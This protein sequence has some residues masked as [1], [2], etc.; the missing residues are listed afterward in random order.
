MSR[1]VARLYVAMTS[2]R[3]ILMADLGADY[4]ATMRG[5]LSG[6]YAAVADFRKD[7]GYGPAPS[8]Q[9]AGEQATFARPGS[10]VTAWSAAFQLI[11]SG[12]E[13]LTAF[14]KTVT[15]PME[16]IA[17]WTCVRSMLESCAIAAWLL[18]PDIDARTRVG[19]IFA[20]RYEGLEQ[21]LKFSRVAGLGEAHLRRLS[22]RI[23]EVE[24]DAIGL[25]YPRVEN[26]RGR[27]I[28]I[29]Q[30]MPSATEVIRLEL[31]EEVNYRLLSAVAHGHQWAI[32]QLGFRPVADRPGE[33]LLGG[34]QVHLIEKAAHPTGIPLL[35]LCAAKAL[36][37]PLWSQ[38]RYFGGDL[39]RLTG[40]FERVFDELRAK[41]VVRFWR[42]TSD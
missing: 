17:C 41:P 16:P 5:A 28:G 35:G 2:T 4:L 15:E 11:E 3:G 10:L 36:A 26:S 18:D 20:L 31:D 33:A 7:Q 25:G 37:R 21:N 14:V 12:G 39:A 8:S 23:D 38:C 42:E 9:A 32:T 27:R 19:R 6:F 1:F 29:G 30:Q 24:R 22:D 13:H 40:L 34:E